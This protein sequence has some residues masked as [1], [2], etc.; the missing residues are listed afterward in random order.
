MPVNKDRI[1]A[2]I[3]AIAQFTQTPGAGATRPTFSSSWKGARDYVASQVES[4][5]CH[6]RIDAAGNLR[7]RPG[8]I[9]WD[10]P[11]WLC[12]SHLDSVRNGGNYDGV[13]GV[14]AAMEV[15]RA[16]REDLKVAC[17]MELVV[18]A[19]SENSSFGQTLIGSRAFIG[20]LS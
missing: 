3:N 4:I 9:A 16:A 14:A 19:G 13:A 5:G 6:V 12:G 10:A 2:D 11:V 8:A 7:A 20:E 18:W 17:P 15:L 1:T